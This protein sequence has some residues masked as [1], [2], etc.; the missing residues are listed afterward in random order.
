MNSTCANIKWWLSR[1][2]AI[3]EWIAWECDRTGKFVSVEDA[4]KHFKWPDKL[5]APLYV[6]GG[7]LF[8]EGSPL[9]NVDNT[10]QY[11]VKEQKLKEE[12]E[13]SFSYYHSAGRA[14][15][16]AT[17]LAKLAKVISD[18]YVNCEP[19]DIKDDKKKKVP[20]TRP[21]VAYRIA[22]L[23]QFVSKN[24]KAEVYTP[25]QSLWYVEDYI[26]DDPMSLQKKL[27]Y[28]AKITKLPIYIHHFD[29]VIVLIR[30]D[31]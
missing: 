1:N 25:N 7:Y 19:D 26:A 9:E 6:K 23:K 18:S 12:Y 30:T 29:G 22:D 27:K 20:Y 13:K 11:R 10:S 16:V 17:Q 15:T 8:G 24:I 14:S 5:E 2:Q 28:A 3:W 4:R 31:M 21:A